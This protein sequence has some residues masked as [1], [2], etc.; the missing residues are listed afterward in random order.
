MQSFRFLKI[1]IVIPASI[2][3]FIGILALIGFHFYSLMINILFFCFGWIFGY[4]LLFLS[5]QKQNKEAYSN[6]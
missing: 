6:E 2:G 5:V 1:F 4:F 3:L